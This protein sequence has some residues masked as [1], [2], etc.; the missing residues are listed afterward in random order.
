MLIGRAHDLESFDQQRLRDF[1]AV[2]I[3]PAAITKFDPAVCW[4]YFKIAL[5]MR[6]VRC[7]YAELHVRNFSAR[8]DQIDR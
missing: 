8:I 6:A 7:Q 2:C 5:A 4:P 3:S 1:E